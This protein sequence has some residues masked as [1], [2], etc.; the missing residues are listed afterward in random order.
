[1]DI[2]EGKK[3]LFDLIQRIIGLNDVLW[4]VGRIYWVPATWDFLKGIPFYF[5]GLAK[6]S[7]KVTSNSL[8]INKF[9]HSFIQ[10]I[11]LAFPMCQFLF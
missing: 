5:P 9:S 8:L 7:S 2:W 10:Y 1:M 11:H 4:E 6:A 3:K